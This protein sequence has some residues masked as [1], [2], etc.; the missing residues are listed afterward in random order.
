MT[1]GISSNAI[2]GNS[3]GIGIK[4]HFDDYQI[5]AIP[6]YGTK[7]K[8]F[9]YQIYLE[10][11]LSVLRGLT[12]SLTSREQAGI[13]SEGISLLYLS[14]EQYNQTSFGFSTSLEKE[15]LFLASNEQQDEE[16][17]QSGRSNVILLTQKTKIPFSNHYS[18]DWN[19]INEQPSQE[20]ETD[21]QYTKFSFRI[22][23]TLYVGHRKWFLFSTL[24]GNSSGNPP[25]QKKF[26]LGSPSTLRGFP[27]TIR[28]MYD[29]LAVAS[30]DFKFPLFYAPL[31]G[32]I[33][34]T[35]IQGVFFY[36]QGKGWTSPTTHST[37]LR[38]ESAGLGIEWVM[39]TLSL[40]QVPIKFEIAYPM[41]DSEYEK[42]QYILLGTLSW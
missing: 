13:R 20:L 38:R 19:L 21:F 18:L 27:Q 12:V 22:N 35:N 9:L 28:L 4:H 29:H 42:P 41:N 11:D 34:A 1:P 36:D 40:F 16:V 39:D 33:S 24:F 8:R 5:Y 14:P 25:L 31:W 17:E 37:A 7:N 6:G 2:D 26:Q 30:L 3:Y 32:D 10:K 23:Q 15:R